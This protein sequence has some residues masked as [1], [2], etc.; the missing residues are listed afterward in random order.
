MEQEQ[1]ER[2]FAVGFLLSFRG[3]RSPPCSQAIGVCLPVSILTQPASRVQLGV[4]MDDE[5]VP[6]VACVTRVLFPGTAHT[7]GL[8]DIDVTCK[9]SDQTK[10]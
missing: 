10:P 1:Y 2:T 5:N 6:T 7:S 9:R 4:K 3:R 8:S